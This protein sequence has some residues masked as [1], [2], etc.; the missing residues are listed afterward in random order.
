MHCA[1]SI[2]ILNIGIIGKVIEIIALVHINE[3]WICI[4]KNFIRTA[5]AL[6]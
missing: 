2:D 3:V 1:K 5:V 6:I 4:E